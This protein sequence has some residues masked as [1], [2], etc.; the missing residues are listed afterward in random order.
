MAGEGI[1]DKYEVEG[2]LGAGG[3][4]SWCPLAT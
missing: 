1:A 2:V 4:G 3:M